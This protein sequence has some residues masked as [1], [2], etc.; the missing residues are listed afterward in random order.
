[1]G[2][3]VCIREMEFLDDRYKYPIFN[4][5]IRI[6][7]THFKCG[8]QYDDYRSKRNGDI[9]IFN[10]DKIPSI[11]CIMDKGLF[12]DMFISLEGWREQQIK[13]LTND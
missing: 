13:L 3:I 1:M 2:R 8:Y 10:I 4:D 7:I 11:L 5:L 6:D 9:S 12:D